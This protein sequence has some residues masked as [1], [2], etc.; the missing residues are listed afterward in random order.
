MRLRKFFRDLPAT[1]IL[2]TALMLAIIAM[3]FWVGWLARDFMR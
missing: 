1:A 3:G 2:G